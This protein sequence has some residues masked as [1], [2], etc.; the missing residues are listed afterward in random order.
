MYDHTSPP[1]DD[2]AAQIPPEAYQLADHLDAA[3][4]AAE[5]LQAAGSTWQSVRAGAAG[6]IAA[7]MAAERAVIER[8]KAFEAMLIGRI[9]KARKRAQTLARTAGDFSGMTRLFVGGTAVLVD[10]VAELG[11]TT[12]ADF[13]TADSML[14]YLRQRGVVAD[15]AS[16]LPASRM[17]SIDQSFLVA[18]RIPLGALC[19]MVAAFLDALEMHYDLYPDEDS[20]PPESLSIADILAAMRAGTMTPAGAAE[21]S[22]DE[23]FDSTVAAVACEEIAAPQCVSPPQPEAIGTTPAARSLSLIE[24]LDAVSPA[25][26]LPPAADEPAAS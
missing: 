20:G 16:D 7:E 1:G 3:L 9:V 2:S 6:D 13:N 25:A 11:D 18:G 5:D 12:L 26:A 10:A 15:D 22:R 24:R 21:T 4:A 17:I 8:V 14:A 23:T 19:D